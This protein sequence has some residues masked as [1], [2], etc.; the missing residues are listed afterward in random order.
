MIVLVT[1]AYG[2]IG[3][4]V[5]KAYLAQ[6]SQLVI[7]GRDPIKLEQLAKELNQQS[8]STVL[9]IAA[10]LNNEADVMDL[11]QQINKSF[12]GLDL[13]VHCAGSLLQKPLMMTRFQEMQEQINNNLLCSVLLCQQASRLMARKKQG[14]ITLMSSIVAQQGSAG[15]SVYAAAKAGIEGLAKSLAKEF[16]GLGVRINALAP[17]VIDTELVAHL[18]EADRARLQQNT[19]LN[20]L[21]KVDDI[22]PV[23]T[24]LSSPGAA[25]ITGQVIAVD[26][27]LVL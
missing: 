12:K 27:G 14:V 4:A 8:A 10:D 7:T 15:Q 22:V 24:F 18:D 6:G 21:G 16:G 9:A 17:G 26:G 20:R 2:G 19:A 13:F 23:V 25:Y 11:F 3:R 5:C 1:G